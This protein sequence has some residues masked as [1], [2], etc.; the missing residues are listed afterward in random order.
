MIKTKLQKESG[1]ILII[2]TL[3]FFAIAM[4]VIVAIASP[5]ISSYQI[6]SSFLESKKTFLL[7]NS[8]SE[9]SMY[10]L[11]TGLAYSDTEY[12]TLDQGTATIN[13][14]DISNGKSVSISGVGGDFERNINFEVSQSEGVSFNYGLQVGQGGYEM[15][16]SAGVNGNVYSNGDITGSG[17]PYITGSATS[18]TV[19]S[20]IAIISNGSDTVPAF[21]TSFGGNSTPQDVA[22]SFVAPGSDPISSVK[23]YIRRSGTGWMNNVT[24]RLTE[25]DGGKPSTSSL[26]TGNIGYTSVTTSYNYLT[27]PFS[28]QASLTPGNTYWVVFD[29]GT[30]WGQYYQLGST[31]SE[32]SDGEIKEGT[33]S[34]KNK[35]N[36]WSAHSPTGSDI[37]FDLFSGGDVG[38][39]DGI[40]V[41]SSGGDAWA[42]T[43]E[44][45][46]VSGN[47]YCQSGSGNNKAC[48][49]SRPDPVETAMP[50]SDGNIE[51]WKTEA[52]AGGTIS[53]NLTYEGS[54]VAYLGPTKVDGNLS[55][56]SGAE[57]YITGTLY[58]TGNISLGGGATI[59]LDSSYGSNSGIVVSDGQIG[60]G[61]GGNF[62]GSGTAGSYLL[63]VTTS[64]CP[65]SGACGG[66][67]AIAASGGTGSVVLS[68]QQGNLV[69]SGGASAK[70]LTAYKIIMSGGT[71][72]TYESGLA[73]INFQSGPSGGWSLRSWQETE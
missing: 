5:V 68:A 34:N 16:G 35:D 41:G 27:V 50:I 49:T 26:A 64:Q 22:Q 4:A 28:T 21:D 55:V 6:S 43:V 14:S 69:L 17:G 1:Q 24:V 56:G 65:Y 33:W 53:G 15:S 31:D 32:Y 10:K 2:N 42:N 45:S 7:A 25:D 13:V 38:L 39:I 51:D 73:D 70:Q 8:A 66:D 71:T 3:I 54:D 30:T 47:L 44:S 59:T 18:A 52:T 19:S 36:D 57:L 20:P 23:F 46:N 48:D 63:V 9:E 58:V 29:T 37:Y 12:V 40:T 72:I 11:K 62:D 60:I 61:G 67:P